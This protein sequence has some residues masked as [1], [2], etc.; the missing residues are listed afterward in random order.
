MYSDAFLDHFQHPRGLGDLAD[1]THRGVADDGACGDRMWV[2]LRVVDG[3]IEGVAYRVEGCAGAIAAGS[4][5]VTLL[6]GRPAAASAVSRT[7]LEATL[8]E[9]PRTKRHALGLA[10]RA[11]HAALNDP[12]GVR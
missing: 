3:R 12:G 4:A 8:E 1:A 11:L 6:P 10:L 5:L 9:V 2:D 7:E